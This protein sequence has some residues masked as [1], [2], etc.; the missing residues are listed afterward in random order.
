ML[1]FHLSLHE[2]NETAIKELFENVLNEYFK[3]R[4][5]KNFNLFS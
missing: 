1:F 3:R 5:K 4:E 2:K